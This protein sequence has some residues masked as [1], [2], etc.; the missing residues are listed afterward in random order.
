[1]SFLIA[2][3]ALSEKYCFALAF[4]QYTS[5]QEINGLE[6]NKATEVISNNVEKI[7]TA[8]EDGEYYQSL[9]NLIDEIPSFNLDVAG[10][11]KNKEFIELLKK[12]L[13]Q[14]LK[15]GFLCFKPLC[16]D[17]DDD[18]SLDQLKAGD[19]TAQITG[20]YFLGQ[21][22]ALKKNSSINSSATS[23]EEKMKLLVNIA[24][25]T[26][27][28]T[29][30]FYENEDFYFSEID[31]LVTP[32]GLPNFQ[33]QK[34]IELSNIIDNCLD[35]NISLDTVLTNYIQSRMIHLVRYLG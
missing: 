25:D 31:K 6:K 27:T 21:L 19:Y 34:K 35:N 32:D 22:K 18:E 20:Q 28:Y 9:L 26:E 10:I 13:I 7:L 24:K 33:Y 17:V 23:E 11:R 5:L 4:A 30:E 1:M 8:V 15:K 29:N 16:I 3:L 14:N 2:K 12:D